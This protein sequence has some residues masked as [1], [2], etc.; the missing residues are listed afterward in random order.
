MVE[1]RP[2]TGSVEELSHFAVSAWKS[3]YGGSVAVPNWTADYFRWQLRL[4]EPDSQRRIVAAYV[5]DQLAG[6][7]LYCPLDFEFHGQP[8]RGAHSSWLS[9]SP[10]HRRMGVG[11]AL[12][13]AAADNCRA[14]GLDF[15]IGYI[16][17]GSQ[18][19]TGPKFWL[20]QGR[21]DQT[22]G[23]NVG[24]WARVLDGQ[25]AAAWNVNRTEQRLTRVAAP[26]VPPPKPR[27]LRG[28]RVRPF[29]PP[30]TAQCVALTQDA[31]RNCQVRLVWGEHLLKHY[32]TGFG[33]CLVAEQDNEIR[34]FIGYHT[35]VFSGLTDEKV[36][37]I[38]LVC[39]D[40]LSRSNQAGLLNSVLVELQRSGAVVALKLRTGD[41]PS[42]YFM[43]W[44]WVPRPRDSHMLFSWCGEPREATGIRRCHV[45]WR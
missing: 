26:F 1:I 23:P 4:D 33:Q 24:F 21:T 45:L 22:V 12:R 20:K 10:D 42:G 44:G 39:A 16:Y 38:D 11:E 18:K 19:S 5:Q 29:Q 41:Y 34:G 9:V 8:A 15:Q 13:Q 2:F 37:V 32:L 31:Y 40:G 28:I 7:L 3:S 30:D 35:L 14:D 43:K 25:K 27:T 36:G 17:H 6:I